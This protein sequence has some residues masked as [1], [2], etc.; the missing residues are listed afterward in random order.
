MS[1]ILIKID[2]AAGQ[3]VSTPVRIPRGGTRGLALSFVQ[4]SA[5]SLLPEGS[6][7]VLEL[8]APGDLVNPIAPGGTVNAWARNADTLDYT[9]SIDMGGPVLAALNLSTLFGRIR[10]T[11]PGEAEA[12]VDDFHVIPQGNPL[13]GLVGDTLRWEQIENPPDLAALG[14]GGA[15]KAEKAPVNGNYRIKANHFQIRDTS[16]GWRT[17]W[18]E[19]GAIKIA[20]ELDQAE[21]AADETEKA[22]KA[23]LN[24][25]YRINPQNALQ[26]Y[27]TADAGWRSVWLEGGVLKISQNIE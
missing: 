20:A 13:P 10:Y 3:L 1:N 19:G 11:E 6:L 15:S 18:L 2:K 26:L 22:E 4:N 24:G 25:N 16:G 23:P 8:F 27:D 5:Q 21:I 17:V 9:A 7:I 12:V 14:T